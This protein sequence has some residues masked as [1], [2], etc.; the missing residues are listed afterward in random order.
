MA[1]KTATSPNRYEKMAAA[2]RRGDIDGI[3]AAMQESP[4]PC[5]DTPE[6]MA[7]L[8]TALANIGKDDPTELIVALYRQM[9]LAQGFLMIRTQ[10]YIDAVIKDH[11]EQHRGSADVPRDIAD[12]WLPRLSR[13]QLEVRETAR[14]FAATMH[15]LA[16][17]RQTNIPDRPKASGR[18]VHLTS[19]RPREAARG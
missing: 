18:V 7:E 8:R 19:V 15:A 1:R 6:A 12:V 16:L 3:F 13:I 9:L 14:A 10:R 17:S 4:M 11:D 5:A 2:A